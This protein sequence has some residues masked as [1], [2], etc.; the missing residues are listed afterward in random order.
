MAV[1]L[2]EPPLLSSSQGE[3]RGRAGEEEEAAA[4]EWVRRRS[5]MKESVE[6]TMRMVV[7]SCFGDIMS[8]LLDCVRLLAHFWFWISS[9][10]KSALG[11]S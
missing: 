11:I 6:K 3:R 8:L 1:P 5:L 7:S 4:E 9:S 10:S 2:P